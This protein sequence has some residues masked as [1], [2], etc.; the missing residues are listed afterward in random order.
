VQE[1]GTTV[2]ETPVV[3]EGAPTCHIVAGPNGSGKSTFAIQYLPR[4]A[5]CCEFVNPDLIALGLSPFNPQHVALKAGKLVLERIGELSRERVDFAFETTLSGSG[6]MNHLRKMKGEGYRIHLYYLWSPSSE[7]LISRIRQRVQAGGHHVP[8]ADVLRRYQRSRENLAMY[9]PLVDS[10]R[11]FDNSQAK[12]ILVYERNGSES[13]LDQERF[14]V[15]RKE[16][17]L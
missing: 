1:Q 12:S 11:L 17:G 4:Y 3:Y 10:L 9:L 16:L 15:I 7:L 14:V 5:G 2:K 13:I 6:Y 8:D